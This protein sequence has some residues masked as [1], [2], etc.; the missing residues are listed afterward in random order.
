MSDPNREVVERVARRA[1]APPP[2]DPP[3][4]ELNAPIDLIQADCMALRQLI[5]GWIADAKA[6]AATWEP[7]P[8]RKE[9]R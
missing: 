6:V 5:R 1:P 8:P 3:V 4:G 2:I 7:R 9:H